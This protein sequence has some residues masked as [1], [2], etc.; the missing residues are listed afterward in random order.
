MGKNTKINSLGMAFK[1]LKHRIL[2]VQFKYQGLE[3]RK[4]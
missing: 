4:K 2:L 3:K 1:F